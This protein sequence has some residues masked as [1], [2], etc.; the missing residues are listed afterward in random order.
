MALSTQNTFQLGE[1]PMPLTWN[2]PAR[3]TGTCFAL[4]T[5]AGSTTDPES[6]R[7]SASARR[8]CA[9]ASSSSARTGIG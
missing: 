6:S 2:A 5:P 3:F 9:A 1:A 8:A 7:T 4:I